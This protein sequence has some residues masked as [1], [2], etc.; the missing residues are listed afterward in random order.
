MVDTCND[1]YLL[2][3]GSN[4]IIEVID[5]EKGRS[6]LDFG[7]GFY[8]TSSRAQA[9]EW[10]IRRAKRSQDGIAILNQYELQQTISVLPLRIKRFETADE[11]WLDYV[12]AN[13]NEVYIGNVYDIVIGPVADDSVLRTIMFYMEGIYTKQEALRRLKTEKLCDQY[14][15]A[16]LEAVS[17]LHFIKAE[18][19]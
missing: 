16:T 12:V 6:K 4:K 5:L 19:V 1:S 11:E 7:K 17:L 8:L 3:H 18:V 10:A 15:F 13:R 9:R 2:Y 14:L